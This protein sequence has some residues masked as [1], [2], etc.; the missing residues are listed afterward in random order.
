[1]K[2][3]PNP[4]SLSRARRPANSQWPG[5]CA[6][7]GGPHGGTASRHVQWTQNILDRFL[8][9]RSMRRRHPQAMIPVFAAR[10]AKHF[11]QTLQVKNYGS[12]Q[13]APMAPQ[14]TILRGINQQNVFH[15]QS[16]VE[17]IR[18]LRPILLP[19]VLLA[20]STAVGGTPRNETRPFLTTPVRAL[21]LAALQHFAA[22]PDSALR[23]R[24]STRSLRQNPQ[25]ASDES[26]SASSTLLTNIGRKHRRI[27]AAPPPSM[28]LRRAVFAS[29]RDSEDIIAARSASAAR[30]Q[31]FDEP[32]HHHRAARPNEIP[33]DAA[34][35]T[36]EV[37]KQLD[38]RLVATKERRGRI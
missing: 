2:A 16:R 35:M 27:E 19:K 26:S 32:D 6:R 18:D 7:V 12:G 15:S 37:L 34:H 33:F 23:Q 1:M 29:P 20:T 38:R 13:R 24:R 17:I 8:C 36:D 25:H 9:N 10:A 5:A 21:R 11:F 22:E 3:T 31:R 30:R 14:T 4:F 28:R